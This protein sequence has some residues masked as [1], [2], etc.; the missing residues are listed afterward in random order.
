[1]MKKWVVCLAATLTVADVC[2]SRVAAQAP[3]PPPAKKPSVS[4]QVQ[5]VISRYQGDKKVGSMPYTLAVL[6]NTNRP[7]QVR[8]GARVPV[9]AFGRTG[10]Q[11]GA[12]TDPGVKAG[13]AALSSYQDIGTNIDC[14]ALTTDDGAF[15]LDLLIDDASLY[16]DEKNGSGQGVSDLPIFRQFRARNGL[17]LKDGQTTQFTAAID[18]VSGEVIR[19]DVSLKVIK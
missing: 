4:L 12:G 6:A 18:R 17:I 15:D 11:P 8:S 19:I 10:G 3:T 14:T 1:M 2:G 5:V 7:A 13:G 9:P 16:L